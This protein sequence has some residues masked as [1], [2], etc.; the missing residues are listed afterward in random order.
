V[1]NT[2]YSA[3]LSAILIASFVH[4]R[5]LLTARKY[6]HGRLATHHIAGRYAQVRQKKDTNGTL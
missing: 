3:W 1:G 6:I 5:G 4:R 2:R